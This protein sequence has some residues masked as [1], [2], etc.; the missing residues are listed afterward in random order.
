MSTS[1]SDIRNVALIGHGGTGKTSLVEQALVRGKVVPKFAPVDGGKSVSRPHA[2]GGRTRHLGTHRGRSLAVEGHQDQPARHAGVRRFR[3][4]GRCRPARQRRCGDGGGRRRRRAD[5]DRQA[6]APAAGGRQTV[7]RVRE[8][9]G[10]GACPLRKQARRLAREAVGQLRAGG[11]ADRRR[12]GVLRRR[13]PSE[14]QGPHPHGR[15]GVSRHGP[16]RPRGHRRGV[17]AGPD[18]GRGRGQRRVDGE[19]PRRGDLERRRGAHRTRRVA[20]RQPGGSGRGGIRDP[21]LRRGEPARPARGGGPVR[22]LGRRPR[23]RR[24][25]GRL[26]VQDQHRPVLRPAVLDQGDERR[27]HARHRVDRHPRRPQ[28]TPHQA[29]YPVR[30][31]TG[32]QRRPGRRRPWRVHQADQRRDRRYSGAAGRADLSPARPAAAG[33][34]GY[35][36]RPVQEGRGTSSASSCR[37]PRRKIPPSRCATTARRARRWCPRWASCS[38]R[39]PSSGSRTPPRWKWRP[40][41]RAL[42]IARPSPGRPPPSISTRSKPAATASTPRWRSGS[43]RC[44]AAR[45]S[46]S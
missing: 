15:P 23:W 2:G 11:G 16:G 25:A 36:G 4:R 30:V 12:G 29:V 13:G 8:P 31:A 24:R 14:R 37:A 42:P 26:R 39:S 3:R 44:R 17:S 45:S 41:C 9:D 20:A 28:G 27:A 6:M 7:H 43:S 22:G 5:R 35:A 34:R 40:T 46:R 18:R 21:E 32:R 10:Q 38:F 1:A 19:V 33:A